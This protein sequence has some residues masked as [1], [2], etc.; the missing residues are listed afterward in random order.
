MKT[1]H[2]RAEA[3]MSVAIYLISRGLHRAA[4]F[5]MQKCAQHMGRAG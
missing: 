2:A 5:N 1:E 4:Q 3:R